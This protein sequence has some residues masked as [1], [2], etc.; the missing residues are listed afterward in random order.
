MPAISVQRFDDATSATAAVMT[1]VQTGDLVLLKASRAMKLET[2]QSAL[3]A[4][5][6]ARSSMNRPANSIIPAPA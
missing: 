1:L 3:T 4:F 2:I 6:E 5:A